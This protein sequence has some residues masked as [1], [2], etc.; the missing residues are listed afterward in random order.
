[1]TM[2]LITSLLEHMREMFKSL[3]LRIDFVDEQ[4]QEKFVAIYE[5]ISDP[6]KLQ[7]L[8]EQQ[9]FRGI[10]VLQYLSQLKMY[11]F[12]QIN[13]INRIS[14]A[15]WWS[16]QDITFSVFELSTSYDLVFNNSLEFY[17][18]NELTKRFYSENRKFD[19]KM[20]H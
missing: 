15:L 12:L 18:D 7:I 13:H 2:V 17:E 16:N 3:A 8:L 5:F 6:D 10:S 20:P 1:M 19:A 11:R 9:D 14:S 4:L